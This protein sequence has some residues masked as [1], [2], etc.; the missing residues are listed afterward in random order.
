MA[1]VFAGNLEDF[2]DGARCIVP[3]DGTEV[4]V[5]AHGDELVAYENRCAH[6]GGP[7]CEGVVLGRVEAVVTPE[8][9]LV[10]ERFSETEPHIVCPWHGWEY[11]LRTG[12]CA[13]DPRF[14]LRRYEVVCREGEV[15]V[16]A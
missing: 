5:I 3:V 11:D 16:R 6:Q 7:V 9:K 2:T 14:A 10:G 12:C 1:E 13:A 4:G 15:Y 8:G